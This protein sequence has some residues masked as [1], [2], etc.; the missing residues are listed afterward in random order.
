MYQ[1]TGFVRF[2]QGMDQDQARRHWRDVHGPLGRAVPGVE[3]YVQNH[4]VPLTG[5]SDVPEPELPY[6]GYA[7]LWFTDEAGR[8]AALATPEW[9]ALVEDGDNF[10]EMATIVSMRI[11]ERVIKDGPRGPFKEICVVRFKAG[12][13][14]DEARD[15]WANVLGPREVDVAPEL[16][17]S[18]QNHVLEALSAGGSGAAPD[19]DGFSERWFPDRD[20]YLRTIRSPGWRR[21]RED[22]ERLFDMSALWWSAVEEIVVK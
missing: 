1:L 9:Q 13:D 8:D 10:L 18:T 22:V 5:V 17:R 12:M 6:D 20:A 15:S 14:A 21:A 16:T 3:G 11:D 4:F 19:F 7:S 2:I